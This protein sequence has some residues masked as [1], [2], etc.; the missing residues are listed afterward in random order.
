MVGSEALTGK[1]GSRTIYQ[2]SWKEAEC[3]EVG[4]VEARRAQLRFWGKWGDGE[5]GLRVVG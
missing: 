1:S 3:H 4:A 2:T 5:Q